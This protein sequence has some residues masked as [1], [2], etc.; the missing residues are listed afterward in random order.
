LTCFIQVTRIKPQTAYGQQTAGVQKPIWDPI[1]DAEFARI[2][3]GS[4]YQL[5]GYAH[6]ENGTAR[7][8]TEPVTYRVAGPPNLESAITEDDMQQPPRHQPNGSPF[9]PGRRVVPAVADAE[10]R[11]HDR[12]LKHVEWDEE[13][14]DQQRQRERREAQELRE[15]RAAREVEMTQVIQE[16]KERELERQERAHERE[17]KLV[18]S[19]G[20]G[21]GDLAEVLKVL[22]PGE[23]A[24]ALARQHSAELRQ[25]QEGHKTEMARLA[26]HQREEAQRHR[27]EVQRLMEQHQAE[28]RRIEEQARQDRARSDTLMREAEQRA[29]ELVREAERRADTRV[30]DTQA[31]AQRQYDDLRARGEER[32]RDQGQTWQQRLDD[33]RLA[34]EREIRQKDS[35]IN[36]MRSNLEG[37][38]AVI[39]G[40]KDEEIKRL[41]REL[42]EAKEQAE[43]NKDWLGRMT[44]FQQTAES[45]GYAKGE[46]GEGEGDLKDMAVRAGLGALQRL[47]EM[48]QSAGDAVAK[49]RAPGAAAAAPQRG[50]PVRSQIQNP[51]RQYQQP[52]P[53]PLPPGRPA[54]P[55]LGFATEDTDY[56]PSAPSGAPMADFPVFAPAAPA[57]APQ[58]YY[59]PPPQQQFVPNELPPAGS[60][61]PQPA[62]PVAAPPQA[63]PP[64][65]PQP[66]PQASVQPPAP[67]PQAAVVASPPSQPVAGPPTLQGGLSQEAQL[68]VTQFAPTLAQHYEQRRKPEDVAQEIVSENGVE[69]S[70]FALSQLTVDQ[71]IQAI[72]ADPGANGALLTRNGQRF[73]R[74]IWAATERLVAG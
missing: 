39:L 49:I 48:I 55:M 29:G 36:L 71:L 63:A 4:E 30:S 11:M 3:G 61:P 60:P 24:Q 26:D 72:A 40:A 68:I 37:N 25:M 2:Y 58:P 17:L 22:R 27:E 45:L 74:D 1:D 20:R 10:V 14:R 31:Q 67:A 9:G 70:R 57:P 42:R 38:Q 19:Q 46:A 44:E 54:R 12:Q 15:R 65:R 7:A 41:Q 69:V 18:Q 73:L 64:P 59:A 66:P 8:I 47:P 34:H 23:E 33:Q 5:R 16:S 53:G 50:A 13:R 62:A 51:P 21:V 28:V 35:E 6:R 32:L 56:V 52:A 43:R